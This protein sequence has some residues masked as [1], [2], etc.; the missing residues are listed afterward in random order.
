MGRVATSSSSPSSWGGDEGPRRQVALAAL[1]DAAGRHR[2]DTRSHPAPHL[3]VLQVYSA[4][5]DGAKVLGEASELG[6][7]LLAAKAPARQEGQRSDLGIGS[8]ASG[9]QV[10]RTTHQGAVTKMQTAG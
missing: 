2:E 6:G 4:K 8:E 7:H 9:V 10:L 3:V 1:G 5:V